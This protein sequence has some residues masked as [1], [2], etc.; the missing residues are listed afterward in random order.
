[1]KKSEPLQMQWLR[2]LVLYFLFRVK[3]GG[4]DEVRAGIRDVLAEDIA[5]AH[6]RGDFQ[7]TDGVHDG[8]GA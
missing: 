2:F 4:G 1:M 3:I 8:E 7:R 6:R 5:D